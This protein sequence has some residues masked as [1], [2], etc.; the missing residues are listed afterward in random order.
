MRLGRIGRE[1][2]SLIPDVKRQTIAVDFDGV[3]HKYS[4]GWHDGTIY[5]EPM[6]G[7]IDG[8]RVLLDKYSVFVFTTRDVIPVAMYLVSH[9][10]RARIDSDQ[11]RTF[12]NESGT[13]LVTNRKLAAIAYVD[14]R[15]VRFESWNQVLNEL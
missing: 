7:A 13:I 3:I 9:G 14:D 5:D 10:I 15:A 6:D 12:W 1:F 4:K 2:K 8:L 11:N